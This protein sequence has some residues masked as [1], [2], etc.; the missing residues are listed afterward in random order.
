MIRKVTKSQSHE[1]AEFTSPLTPLL[2]VEGNNDLNFNIPSVK[3][4]LNPCNPWNYKNEL[5]VA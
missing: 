4:V 1:V 3:S 5:V 2:K